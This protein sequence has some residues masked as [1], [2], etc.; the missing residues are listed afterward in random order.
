LGL[1]THITVAFLFLAPKPAPEE[2]EQL[3]AAASGKKPAATGAV[4]PTGTIAASP[5]DLERGPA[6]PMGQVVKSPTRRVQPQ[7]RA[8]TALS[9]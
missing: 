8:A 2:A 7:R 5:R 3:D 4:A 1:C 9:P 6:S